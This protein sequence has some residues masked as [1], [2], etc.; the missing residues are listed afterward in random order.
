LIPPG[1]GQVVGGSSTVRIGSAGDAW[2]EVP[3]ALSRG[4]HGYRKGHYRWSSELVERAFNGVGGWGYFNQALIDS[5][6]ADRAHF[7][8]IYNDPLERADKARP[9]VPALP[10]TSPGSLARRETGLV[11]GGTY[12]L[13]SRRESAQCY[14]VCT[15]LTHI[16]ARPT[17][18][19]MAV[20]LPGA[21]ITVLVSS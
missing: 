20:V 18:A 1:Q 17:D 4:E 10:T 16:L 9:S 11:A 5:A 13:Q 8:R 6:M 3:P 2:K 7:M 19:G 12:P 21:L 14:P 15:G